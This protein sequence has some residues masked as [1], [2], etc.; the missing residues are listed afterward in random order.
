MSFYHEIRTT[1]DNLL[2][3]V[4]KQY[5]RYHIETQQIAN[6]NLDMFSIYIYFYSISKVIFILRLPPPPDL[7]NLHLKLSKF[8][9][10]YLPQIILILNKDT[11]SLYMNTDN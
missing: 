11:I 9:Q 7:N 5:Y 8:D 4:I 2:S 6:V 10:I 1:T 3:V